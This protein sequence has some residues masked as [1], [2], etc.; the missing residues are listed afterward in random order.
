MLEER[1]RYHK[2]YERLATLSFTHGAEL[3]PEQEAEY[4]AIDKIRVRSMRLAEKSVEHSRWV[5]IV[6]RQSLR[7]RQ[8]Q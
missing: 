1:L 4:E 8:E 3:T 6:I 5:I 7:K 2:I